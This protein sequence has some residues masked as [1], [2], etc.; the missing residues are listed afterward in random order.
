MLDIS[1]AYYNMGFKTVCLFH[2]DVSMNR[3]PIDK[4]KL[5]MKGKWSFIVSEVKYLTLSN[6]EFTEARQQMIEESDII[7]TPQIPIRATNEFVIFN[8][9]FVLAFFKKYESIEI[10]WELE[11]CK[12]PLWGDICLYK[13]AIDYLG[14]NSILVEQ[15]VSHGASF[16]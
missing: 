15:Y 12:Y 2:S 13:I 4:F 6:S 16:G 8:K 11:F 3:N 1:K 14:F 7:K 10:A 9:E 5:L